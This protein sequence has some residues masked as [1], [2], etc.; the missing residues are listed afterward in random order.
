MPDIRRGVILIGR[1]TGVLPALILAAS[2]CAHA[3]QHG[4]HPTPAPAPALLLAPLA[5][6]PIAV[7]PAEFVM[8]D[9]GI[10]GVPESRA[11]RLAWADSVFGE[12][13]QAR[14]PEATWVLAPEVRR[15]ARR[16]PGILTDPDHMSQ[17][18]MRF[19]NLKRVPDPLLS[20]I[21]ALVAFTGS[22]F[23]MIPAAF[24]ITRTGDGV[25]VESVLV[26]AD[27]R[28]GMIPWRSTPVA[29]GPTA[30]AALAA[31]IARV[32]PDLH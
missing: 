25:Q 5:G 16:A 23:V 10:A 6:Q 22:R 18:V 20:N 32:L 2:A 11:G 1:R 17:A 28:S 31:T 21:R 29:T 26:L 13:L 19:E 15:V 30:A 27:A 9:S 3:Q 4:G 8:V 14:G 12:E 24:R 7:L